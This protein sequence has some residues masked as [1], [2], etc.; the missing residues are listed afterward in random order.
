[1]FSAELF[2]ARLRQLRLAA[3]LSQQGLADIL[4][5]TKPTVSRMENSQRAASI[6]VFCVLADY[7]NVSIDYLV[8][9]TDN[10]EVNR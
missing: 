6:E 3:H 7:F 8:G 9:L 10:P 5:V 1:M 2:S 4:Q